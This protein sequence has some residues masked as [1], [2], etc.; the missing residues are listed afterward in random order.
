MAAV[1]GSLCEAAAAAAAAATP[2]PPAMPGCGIWSVV[3]AGCG[4][5]RGL[6]FTMA[7]AVGGAG[8]FG[9]RIA[10]GGA[11][12][13][14]GAEMTMVP[15]AG[16]EVTAFATTAGDVER[17]TGFICD[18]AAATELGE[19]SGT[20]A[21]VGGAA[22]RAVTPLVVPAVVGGVLMVTAQVVESSNRHSLLVF[23]VLT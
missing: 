6:V 17:F 14:A 7:A 5:V 20:P 22:D 3:L 9:M 11:T 10:E 2:T 1:A 13:P 18:G 23:L 4:I 15:G 8:T 12:E 16:A 19:G 21:I